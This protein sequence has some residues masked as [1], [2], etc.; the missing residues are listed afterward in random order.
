[1]FEWKMK[2]GAEIKATFVNYDIRKPCLIPHSQFPP[3]A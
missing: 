3:H 1:M 2:P